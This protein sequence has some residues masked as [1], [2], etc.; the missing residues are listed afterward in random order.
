MGRPLRASLGGYVYQVPQIGEMAGA[1]FSARMATTTPRASW[2]HCSWRCAAAR[3]EKRNRK[4]WWRRWLWLSV[5]GRP[6]RRIDLRIRRSRRCAGFDESF[7]TNRADRSHAELFVSVTPT[8][9][10]H[11]RLAECAFL[12]SEADAARTFSACWHLRSSA[13]C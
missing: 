9:G 4:L 13:A 2:R 10:A 12:E 1:P 6:F 11:L 8:L 7:A 3:G 5:H